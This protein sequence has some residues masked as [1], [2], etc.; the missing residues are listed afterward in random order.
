M[1]DSHS[2]DVAAEEGAVDRVSVTDEIARF[3]AVAREGLEHL[4]NGPLFSWML[5]DGDVNDAA[6]VVGKDHEAV[7]RLESQRGTVKKSQAAVTPR[8]FFRNVRQD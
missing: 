8:W 4:S 6:T 1:L 2:I 7:Q 3:A 5:G